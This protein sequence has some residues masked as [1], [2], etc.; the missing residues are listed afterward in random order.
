[1]DKKKQ[2]QFLIAV[3]KDKIR[4]PMGVCHDQHSSTETHA[5]RKMVKN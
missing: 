1:M 2:L 3:Y 5:V 4:S